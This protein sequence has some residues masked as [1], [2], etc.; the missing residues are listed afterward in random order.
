MIVLTA[1]FVSLLISNG[2][3]AQAAAAAGFVS[4]S[5][6]SVRYIPLDLG[7]IW[8]SRAFAVLEP[9][10][11]QVTG[12]IFFTQPNPNGPVT[13][14]G[15]LF[16]LDPN[17]ERGIH[18]HRFGNLTQKCE[19]TGEHWNAANTTHG[20]ISNPFTSRH[21]GDLGTLKPTRTGRRR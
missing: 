18:I 9:D 15:Q 16:G 3:S 1:L 7:C 4:R 14:T 6:S 10:A 19:S 5:P 11:A 2:V 8:T 17:A 13:V 21:R 12:T 20:D